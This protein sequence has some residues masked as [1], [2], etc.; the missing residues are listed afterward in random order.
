MASSPE[1]LVAYATMGNK[2]RTAA[3]QLKRELRTGSIGLT[4]ALVDPRA[5][6]LEVLTLCSVPYRWGHRRAVDLLLRVNIPTN[7]RVRELTARQRQKLI[8]G[9]L[10]PQ[11]SAVF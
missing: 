6:H 7:R 8:H 3:A 10:D 9:Y 1:T 5:S 4:D 11:F 2:V